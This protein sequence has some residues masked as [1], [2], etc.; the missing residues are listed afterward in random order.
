M[1]FRAVLGKLLQLNAAGVAKLAYAADSKWKLCS[2][3]PLLNSSQRSE[4]TEEN[5]LD[6]LDPFAGLLG[7]F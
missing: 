5:D 1:G 3:C 2:F 7:N 6:A 4:T